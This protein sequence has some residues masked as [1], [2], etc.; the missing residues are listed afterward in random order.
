VNAA[1]GKEGGEGMV[2]EFSAIVG[3]LTGRLNCVDKGAKLSNVS[4]YLG[5]VD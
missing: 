2:D 3:A 1:R 5:L 4:S